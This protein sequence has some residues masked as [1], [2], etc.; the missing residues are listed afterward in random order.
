M[1]LDLTT[2]CQIRTSHDAIG[3]LKPSLQSCPS[4]T[5]GPV[6]R[7]CVV[8]APHTSSL[9]PPEA[10]TTR[11]E[12]AT[13]ATPARM[14]FKKSPDR[15]KTQN[16]LPPKNTVNPDCTAPVEKRRIYS[17]A[18]IFRTGSTLVLWVWNLKLSAPG[19]LSVL[20]YQLLVCLL[21]ESDPAVVMIT[22]PFITVYSV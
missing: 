7:G 5:A 9:S 1:L 6:D 17:A 4:T 14:T 19:P 8:P 12:C 10:G 15:R 20:T 16:A 21:W 18:L 2:G 11:S 3:A 13:A 22:D